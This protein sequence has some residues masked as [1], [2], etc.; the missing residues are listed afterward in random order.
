MIESK[1][2]TFFYDE[3]K[4]IEKKKPDYARNLLDYS[5]RDQLLSY[6][7]EQIK[8]VLNRGYKKGKFDNSDTRIRKLV[9]SCLDLYISSFEQSIKKREESPIK[10]MIREEAFQRAKEHD[11]AAVKK[12][13]TGELEELKG[14][15]IN[16][17]DEEDFRRKTKE[18]IGTTNKV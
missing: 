12:E 15:V 9:K 18:K 10:K 2:E 5:R 7:K 13:F 6:F 4:V 8:I 16:A 1:I 11:L 17:T 3:I 14:A